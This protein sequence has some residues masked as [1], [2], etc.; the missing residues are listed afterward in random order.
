MKDSGIVISTQGDLAQVKV[1]CLSACQDCSA[2]ALCSHH[3]Q[4]EGLLS[5]KNHVRAC[6]GDEVQIDVPEENYNRAL[7]LLFGVLLGAALMGALCGY[8]IAGWL[9][10]PSSQG[11]L[12]GFFFAIGAAAIWLTK[13]FRKTNAINLYPRITGIIQKG[14]CHG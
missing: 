10:L 9:S 7:I 3:S 5:V 12:L 4:A 11:G 8:L 1:S 14:D 6:T 13:F 2:S